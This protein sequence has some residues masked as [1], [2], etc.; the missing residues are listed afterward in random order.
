MSPVAPTAQTRALTLA[1]Q[2]RAL[3]NKLVILRISGFSMPGLQT[4][5]IILVVAPCGNTLSWQCTAIP[6]AQ[7]LA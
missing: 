2:A 1:M 7:V 5:D 4:V 3:E 6:F